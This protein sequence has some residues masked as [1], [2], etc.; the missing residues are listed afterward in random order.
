MGNRKQAIA[1]GFAF[2]A[3]LCVPFSFAKNEEKKGRGELQM[4]RVIPGDTLHEIARLYLKDP[5]RW[6]ELLKYN[7]LTSGDPN[8]IHPGDRLLVP[9][10][11]IKESM[12][13]AHL[14]EK[15]NRV[16]YRARGENV[17]R[18]AV[19]NQKIF[20]EDAIRTFANSYAKILFP[21]KEITKI[22]PN[23]LAIIRPREFKQEV[24]LIKGE[25][26]ATKTKIL[27]NSA[28]I[29]PK[30]N[31]LFKAKVGDDKT[32]EVEVYDGKIDVTGAGK[33]IELSKG[34][35]SKIELG[36]IP[37]SPSKVKLPDIKEMVKLKG[38]LT[39]PASF[40][41]NAIDIKKMGTFQPGEIKLSEDAKKEKKRK[42][43]EIGK[44]EIS[45]DEY[46]SQIILSGKPAD[47]EKKVKKLVD[48]RYF[49]RFKYRTGKG[50]SRYSEVRSFEINRQKN[51]LNV[52][53]LY[54]PDGVAVYDEFVEVKGSVSKNIA[55]LYIDSTDTEIAEDGTFS[56]LIYL[57]MGPHEIEIIA[58]DRI[59]N[60][61]I[62]TRKVV[63]KARKKGFFHRLFGG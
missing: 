35:G 32:T 28:V 26:Y 14:I 16:E 51:S 49:Y 39:L 3:I 59:G 57:P 42:R 4:I 62:L 22:S 50:K 24:N 41:M 47:I 61:R 20:F 27:T 21:T 23:A 5:S 13:A 63:R 2:F 43:K 11:E 6:P 15:T 53:V 58:S 40:Q 10:E 55:K 36:K 34:F 30:E 18:D 46:F 52:V 9:V 37:M 7:V 60:R 17:F 48:G 29:E 1:L 54:P 45:L 25:I 38:D 33:K 8:L 12:R 31:S 56:Q 44:V 19:L